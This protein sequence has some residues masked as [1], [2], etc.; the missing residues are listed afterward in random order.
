MVRNFTKHYGK[1]I[2]LLIIIGL[3]A[4]CT[5]KMKHTE[6]INEALKVMKADAA[7]LGEAKLV[8]DTL[9]F[10]ATKINNNFEIVD[11]LNE[12]FGCSATFFM[13]KGN[14]FI[15]VSTGIMKDD[16]SAVGTKLDPTGPVIKLLEKGLPYFGVADVLGKQY[17][18]GYEP[19]KTADGK[20]IGAYFVGFRIIQ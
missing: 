18:A 15:R 2:V 1:L 6:H 16:Q 14:D 10:G 8:A 5:Q 20:I 3:T 7:K 4:G 17:E 19:I 13:K 11:A 9:F 12:K